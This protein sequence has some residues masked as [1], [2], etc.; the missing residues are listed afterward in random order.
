M[1]CNSVPKGG[2]TNTQTKKEEEGNENEHKGNH[3]CGVSSHDGR[4][5]VD[6]RKDF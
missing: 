5:Q 6:Q 2:S 4:Q 3:Y 1:V